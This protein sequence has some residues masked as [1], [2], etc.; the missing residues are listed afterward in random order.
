MFLKTSHTHLNEQV[1]LHDSAACFQSWITKTNQEHSVFFQTN[2]IICSH[3]VFLHNKQTGMCHSPGTGDQQLQQSCQTSHCL[4]C[5]EIYRPETHPNIL[6]KKTA[7]R[8]NDW[9]LFW[10][11]WNHLTPMKPHTRVLTFTLPASPWRGR[12]L[13]GRSLLPVFVRFT[14]SC[15]LELYN[16]K[17]AC[18][19]SPRIKQE[20][21]NKP[22]LS[23]VC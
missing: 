11:L 14:F 10:N 12:S 17:A 15:L 6:K 13:A 8:T 19:S 5:T 16:Q 3:T 22:P 2:L 23:K 9:Q 18:G 21:V 1:S 7:E 4:N 20:E